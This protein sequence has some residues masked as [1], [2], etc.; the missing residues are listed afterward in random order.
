MGAALGA[1]PC[2]LKARKPPEPFL[3]IRSKISQCRAII[4]RLGAPDNIHLLIGLQHFFI[5]SDEA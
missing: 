4:S 2:I 3:E 5:S 1:L